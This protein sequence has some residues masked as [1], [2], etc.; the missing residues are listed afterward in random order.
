MA[1]GS[2][3]IPQLPA[4]TA[5]RGLAAWWVVLYH[6]RENFPDYVPNVLMSVINRGYLGVDLFFE[7]SGFVIALNY[8]DRFDRDLSLVRY[9]KFLLVRLARVYPL[10]AFMMFV[11]IANPLAIWL[12]SS[13]R[14]ESGAYG[15]GY[16][17]LSLGL[18]QNWGFVD[19]LAWN[20]PA[21]SISTEWFVYLIF[22]IIVLVSERFGRSKAVVGLAIGLLLSLLA[23]GGAI[24]GG[25][26]ADI[27]HFGLIRCVLEFAAGVLLFRMSAALSHNGPALL[28]GALAVVVFALYSTFSPPDFA[29]VPLGFA[30]LIAAI[31]PQS[32]LPARLLSVR[33]IEQIGLVSYS[34]YLLHFF[35][36]DWVKFLMVSPGRQPL[37]PT[38]VYVAATLIG[39][40]VLYRLIEMPGRRA[41]RRLVERGGGTPVRSSGPLEASPSGQTRMCAGARGRDV[42]AR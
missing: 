29:V 24:A 35:V 17:I 12:F 33:V 8:Y 42:A 9:G 37:A 22:P 41:L 7:L 14:I 34:T 19:R 16:F 4:L 2:G 28:P 20:I 23:V 11:F 27:P 25:L 39:S 21:W 3:R 1:R 15:L 18:V 13:H 31:V 40:V 36:R 30:L 38:L 32:G 26:G 10:H 6:F 5:I